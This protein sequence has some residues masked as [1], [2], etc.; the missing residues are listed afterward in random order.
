MRRKAIQSL[1]IFAG[2]LL[3]AQATLPDTPAANRL[4]E[5]LQGLA[6]A[7]RAACAGSAMAAGRRE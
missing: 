4:Q 6:T 7:A 1:L 3:W 5:W 2:C